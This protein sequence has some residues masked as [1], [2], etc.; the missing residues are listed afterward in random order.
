M[1]FP[2]RIRARSAEHGAM[3]GAHQKG[4]GHGS[5]EH[6]T[7]PRGRSGGS[8]SNFATN[9]ATIPHHKAAHSITLHPRKTLS[10]SDEKPI[11]A[12]ELSR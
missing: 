1:A 3:V 12:R 7:S 9:F 2:P 4:G 10:G 8:V 5:V 6:P 11:P